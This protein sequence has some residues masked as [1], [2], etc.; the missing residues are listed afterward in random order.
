M[1][2]SVLLATALTTCIAGTAFAGALEF[3]P[4]VEPELVAPTVTDWSGPYAGVLFATGSATQDFVYDGD[5]TQ[6]WSRPDLEG[7]M[8]GAFA[9]YNVQRDSYFFG[10]E[11]A[12]STGS[13]VEPSEIFTTQVRSLPELTNIIDLKAR[14]GIVAGDALIYGFAG[15]SMGD[16]RMYDMYSDN[17]YA[18]DG[19]NYGVGADF[20]ITDRIFI[21][22]D[23]IVRDLS[24]ATL[25]N[26]TVN[27]GV[28]AFEL[29]VGMNF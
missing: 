6:S 28:Q 24:G 29:R 15:W 5:G 18:V 1:M 22:A 20:L 14:A 11:G 8:Y 7:T 13:F 12:Y 3:V 10:V 4:E 17:T 19:M 25:P 2:K 21:G 27:L 16:Y 9:G 23:Y 26:E